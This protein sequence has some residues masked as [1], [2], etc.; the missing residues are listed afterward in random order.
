LRGARSAGGGRINDNIRLK[1]DDCGEA[2][3]MP[4]KM[5]LRR[6]GHMGAMTKAE[7]RQETP[8]E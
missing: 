4:G 1:W 8:C 7:G 6:G 3:Q 2:W 5:V